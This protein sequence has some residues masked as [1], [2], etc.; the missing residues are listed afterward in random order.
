MSLSHCCKYCN[1]QMRFFLHVVSVAWRTSGMSKGVSFGSGRRHRGFDV[2]QGVGTRSR[3]SC[4]RPCSFFVREQVC[5]RRVS[6]VVSFHHDV[7]QRDR[8]SFAVQLVEAF[9][10]NPE[11]MRIFFL[12]F[13]DFFFSSVRSSVGLSVYFFFFT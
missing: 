2:F 7:I 13:L 3:P 4:I 8:F 10:S 11:I 9:F 12:K 1:M 5:S 6:A